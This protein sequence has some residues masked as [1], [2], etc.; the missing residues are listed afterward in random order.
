[1]ARKGRGGETGERGRAKGRA[2]GKGKVKGG[3]GRSDGGA[4]SGEAGKSERLP[5]GLIGGIFDFE[6]PSNIQHSTSVGGEDRWEE[7]RAD[8]GLRGKA[9]EASGAGGQNPVPV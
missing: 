8:K 6:Q 9:K 7:G 5:T 2:E 3:K 4:R 1:M